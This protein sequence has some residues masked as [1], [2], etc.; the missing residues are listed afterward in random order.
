[1][2]GNRIFLAGGQ[3]VKQA[4]GHETLQ[5]GCDAGAV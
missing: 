3:S 2:G 4:D 5:A 1:M